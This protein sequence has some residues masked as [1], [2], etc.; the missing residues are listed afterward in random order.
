[1]KGRTIGD[2]NAAYLASIAL[3][4]WESVYVEMAALARNCGAIIIPSPPQGHF[5]AMRSVDAVIADF[6]KAK[7]AAS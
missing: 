3:R 6:E 5:T 1:M 4:Q 7:K 2:L